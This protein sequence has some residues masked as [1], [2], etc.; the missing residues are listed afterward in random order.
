MVDIRRLGGQRNSA[1]QP[2]T[3]GLICAE[4]ANCDVAGWS[5]WG[6]GASGTGISQNVVWGTECGGA[7][8][9]SETWSTS[10][11]DDTVVWGNSGGDDDDTVVWGNSGGDDDD[12]VVW[13]NSDD[14]TV[15]W[16]NNCSTGCEQ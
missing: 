8:C 5:T 13:G 9:S 10:Y 11:D 4:G 7:N 1:G 14:D 16:G 12:T 3:W 6:T 15:V 2:V